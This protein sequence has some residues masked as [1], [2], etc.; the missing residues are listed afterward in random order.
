[1]KKKKKKVKIKITTDKYGVKFNPYDLNHVAKL[2]KDKNSFTTKE[3]Y[4]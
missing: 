1:M 4:I 3:Y 2:N